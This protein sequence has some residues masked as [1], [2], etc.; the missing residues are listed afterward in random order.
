MPRY[1][2]GF[3]STDSGGHAPRAAMDDIRGNRSSQEAGKY[4][5]TYL[6]KMYGLAITYSIDDDLR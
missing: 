1:A 2:A 5:H 6:T 4:W 3:V